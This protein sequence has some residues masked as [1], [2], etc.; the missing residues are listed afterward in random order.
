MHTNGLLDKKE[1]YLEYKVR[2]R[3][4]LQNRMGFPDVNEYFHTSQGLSKEF[5]QDGSCKYFYG[6]TIVFPLDNDSKDKL[7]LIQ[8]ELYQVI[9]SIFSEDLPKDTFHITLHDLCAGENDFELVN[10]FLEH[11]TVIPKILEDIRKQGMIKLK[12]KG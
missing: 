4:L 8:K 10:M 12:G 6:D 1:D 2:I 11:K 9:P 5:N 7:E 3:H